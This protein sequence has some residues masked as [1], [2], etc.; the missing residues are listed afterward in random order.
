MRC[1]G[2]VDNM[3]KEDNMNRFQ[4][5]LKDSFCFSLRIIR[6]Q[7]LVR[8]LKLDTLIRHMPL[9]YVFGALLLTCTLHRIMLL[10]GRFVQGVAVGVLCE[11]CEERNMTVL[12]RYLRHSAHIGVE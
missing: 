2:L 12:R 11:G 6:Y 7:L 4:A 9:L 10:V 8:S 1:A 3:R 5:F